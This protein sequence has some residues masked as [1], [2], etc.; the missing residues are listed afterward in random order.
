VFLKRRTIFFG[1]PLILVMMLFLALRLVSQGQLLSGTKLG[2]SE[3]VVLA[4][5]GGFPRQ[6]I[7][8]A[9]RNILLQQPTFAIV[10][11]ILAGDEMLSR[12]VDQSRVRSVT[13]LADEPGI[14]N[15]PDTYSDDI[16][17]NHGAVEEIISMEPD[18]VIV[19]AYS[20]A[21]SVEMLLNAGIP[22]IRF[23]N[24]HS[25][26]D[27]RNNV[28]TLA[29]AT[30]SEPQAKAWLSEMDKRIAEVQQRVANRPKPRVLYYNLSGSTSGPGSM[31]DETINLAGGRNVIGETGLESYV[32]ISPEMA[33]SLQPDVILVSDWAAKGDKTAKQI[34]QKDPAWKDVPAIINQRVYSVRGA[35][36]TSGSPYRVTGVEAIA[37]LLH[38][39]VFAGASAGRETL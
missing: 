13:Y 6:I 2:N 12:L 7:D 29:K 33:I 39:Q 19:A 1:M 26:D 36:L 14:S 38:P 34:L 10:S 8:P 37:R 23:A 31:M 32:Q 21:T 11:G 5:D 24:F 30:G 9:G 15:V 35:W 28:R 4:T 17:R 3:V 20:D 22:I 25:Y 18:L 16:F 27:V